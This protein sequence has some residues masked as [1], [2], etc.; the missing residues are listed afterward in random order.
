MY[1]NLNITIYV[2]VSMNFS[3]WDKTK[4]DLFVA[5][6]QTLKNC[7]SVITVIFNADTLHIQGMD[8]SHVCMFN[9]NIVKSWFNEYSVQNETIISFDSHIFYTIISSAQKTN[10]IFIRHSDDDPD[11]L[12]VDLI[13]QENSSGDFNKY[14]KIPLV[15][16]DFELMNIPIIEYDAEFS[17]AS[18][19]ICDIVTQMMLFGDNINIKCTEETVDLI[20]NGIVG[21]MLVNIPINDLN[22]YSVVEGETIDLKYS[23]NY[24]HK[25]CL[26]N[27]L[28]NEIHFF[29]SPEFPMKIK[30]DLGQDC[31]IVFYIAPKITD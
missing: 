30:Y 10:S 19:K 7:T 15:D 11:N 2:I 13:S 22:E 9:V 4:K 14:F 8:K 16:C 28:S 26:T 24:I 3:I 29:V 1:T 18:K 31:Y 5:L 23:L 27:N 20:T 6:F 25:M 21:E 17:I 12:H